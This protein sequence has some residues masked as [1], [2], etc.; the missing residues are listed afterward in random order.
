MKNSST[1]VIL[2]I[3][4]SSYVVGQ[5]PQDSLYLK[6]GSKIGGKLLGKSRTEYKF[7]SSD[8][9]LFTV[10]S[11]EIKK[12]IPAIDTANHMIIK[13]S[14]LDTLTIEQLNLYRDNALK[15]RNA[16]KV[17]TLGGIGAGV[18]GLLVGAIITIKNP[19]TFLFPAGFG[20]QAI[21]VLVGI[22]C[23]VVGIP[24]WAVGDNRK[25]KAEL[26]LQKYNFAPEGSMAY[27]LGVTIRF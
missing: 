14:K 4:V 17:L 6:N 15:L 10:S 8:G 1:I 18:T 9:V 3:L 25:T 27:G 12:I 22:P 20:A 2:L 5:Q 13:N 23:I 7:Q 16:G 21:G 26:T 11:Y 19:D 24:M